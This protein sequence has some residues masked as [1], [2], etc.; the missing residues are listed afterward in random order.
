MHVDVKVWHVL[1]DIIK[2]ISRIMFLYCIHDFYSQ[3]HI[4]KAFNIFSTSKAHVQIKA[5]KL[6]L[7]KTRNPSYYI[8]SN[9][10]LR[11]ST[12]F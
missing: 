1:V 9:V 4:L 7:L 2:G 5:C 11:T 6:P 12:Q 10:F 3:K 8:Y